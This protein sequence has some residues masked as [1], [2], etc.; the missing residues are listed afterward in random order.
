MTFDSTKDWAELVVAV[1]TI[2]GFGYTFWI[3]LLRKI[4][5][6]FISNPIKTHLIKINQ[7]AE[8]VGII[9]S[10]I[11]PVIQSLNKEFSKNSGKSIMDRILRIDDLTRLSEIRTKLFY[12]MVNTGII[13]FDKV[14][15]LVWANKSFADMTGLEVDNL[16]DNGWVMTI[17]EEDRDKVWKLWQSSIIHNI[18]FESE[19]TL[20]H[21]GTNS[22]KLVKCTILP[23]KSM[24][25]SVIGYYG[26]VINI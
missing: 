4:F 13:E 16:I 7:M 18:P 22:T 6:K 19:F 8:T 24:D 17:E 10:E 21:Q 12:N 5:Q 14:G 3:F 15:H 26:T 20:K 2:L 1:V 23:F 25:G 9:N 11:L